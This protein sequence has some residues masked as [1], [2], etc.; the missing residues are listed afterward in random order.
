MT[1]SP[2]SGAI[3]AGRGVG[4]IEIQQADLCLQIEASNRDSRKLVG[5]RRSVE[6]DGRGK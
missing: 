6:E 5:K 4:V 3:G 1:S 2:L